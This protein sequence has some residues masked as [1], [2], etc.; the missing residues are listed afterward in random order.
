MKYKFSEG[1]TEDGK[2][3]I[4]TDYQ[5]SDYDSICRHVKDNKLKAVVIA[6]NQGGYDST[7]VCL[8]CILEAAKTII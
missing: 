2:F 4:E 1:A 6:V 5:L 7:V 3:E 8:E